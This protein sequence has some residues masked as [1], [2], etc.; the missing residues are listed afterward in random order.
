M[1]SADILLGRGLDIRIRQANKSVTVQ[2]VKIS[3]WRFG[4]RMAYP[5]PMLVPSKC[6]YPNT[7]A[8]L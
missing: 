1:R 3:R 6:A 8:R 5:V 4:L 7:T 2:P